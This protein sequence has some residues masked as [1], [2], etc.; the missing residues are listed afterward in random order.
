MVTLL[1]LTVVMM[2]G[3]S[4]AN[5]ALHSEKASRND[6]DRQIAF[7]AAEA[8]LVDAELDIQGSPDVRTTRSVLFDGRQVEGFTKECG[9][10]HA[11]LYLGLCTSDGHAVPVW[12]AVDF[13][14]SGSQ[15]RSVPYGY[16]TGQDFQ[17]AEGSLPARLPRYIVEWIPMP[18]A[19][20]DPNDMD[21]I[22]LYRITAVGFGVRD[23]TQV[24]L[25]TY[26][27]KNLRNQNQSGRLGWR[28]MANWGELHE[29]PVR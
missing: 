6:R 16:F 9:L 14:E 7:Q 10:G 18:D 1:M 25:Q 27:R 20:Q 26:Y 13:M 22:H 12:Q 19:A 15:S 3:I 29:E 21:V 17:A 23:T 8:A 2:M 24:A 5:I 28:E 11:D 4:A